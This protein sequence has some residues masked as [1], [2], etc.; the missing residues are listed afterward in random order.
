MYFTETN[1]LNAAPVAH[2]FS[3]ADP[4]LETDVSQNCPKNDDPQVCNSYIPTYES[5]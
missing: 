1:A 5:V 4:P 3:P 2:P